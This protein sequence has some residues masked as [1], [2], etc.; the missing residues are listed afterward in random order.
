MG[1]PRVQKAG[2]DK[3]G[4]TMFNKVKDIVALPNLKLSVLFANGTTK[5]YDVAPLMDRFDAFKRLE[6]SHLF[7][8]VEVDAG[9]YG[10][11]W[12][13]DLD[14][15]CDELW[16]NGSIV[17]TP[18]DGLMSFADASEL[19][20]LSESALRKAIT[21]G[22]IVSGVDARKYGKQWVITR[23]AMEREYGMPADGPKVKA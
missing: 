10:I 7:E 5:M 8:S 15:S 20:G 2:A 4:V 23:A 11:V 21:Y 19:W 13:D 6:D 18:F 3:L 9:G 1:N 17:S 16:E 22:K 12:D 14:L